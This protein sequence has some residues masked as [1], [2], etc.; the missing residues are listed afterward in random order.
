M[1]YAEFYNGLT[2]QIDEGVHLKYT[3]P[4]KIT[5]AWKEELKPFLLRN[6]AIDQGKSKFNVDLVSF[7]VLW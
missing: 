4:Q 6:A 5:T 3:I 2:K 1:T 7:Y